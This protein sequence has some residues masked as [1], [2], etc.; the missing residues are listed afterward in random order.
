M[1]RPI[2]S[3]VGS[4]DLDETPTDD[5]LRLLGASAAQIRVLA[6]ASADERRNIY[7]LMLEALMS[8]D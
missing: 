6:C 3:E 5:A 8:A 2:P 4:V 1:L 7:R